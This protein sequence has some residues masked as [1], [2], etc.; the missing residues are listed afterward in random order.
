MEKKLRR[1][2]YK[3]DAAEISLHELGLQ[4]LRVRCHGSLVRL[5]V[6]CKDIPLA[7][8]PLRTA[9]LDKLKGMGFTYVTLD[10]QGYHSGSMNAAI[11]NK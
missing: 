5:E 4:E 8:G 2:H 10:L 7:A 3:I 6:A 1:Q 9:I 11:K